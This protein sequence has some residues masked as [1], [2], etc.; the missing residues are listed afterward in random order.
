[1]SSKKKGSPHDFYNDVWEV[2]RLIPKGR[3]TTYGAIAHFLGTGMSARMVGWAINRAPAGVPAHRVINSNGLLT[4]KHHFDQPDTMQKK[5]E[6]E[7][8]RV[9]KDQVKDLKKILWDPSSLT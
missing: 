9:E 4:G 6:A 2:V 5:L 1:M 8:I 7:G 3:V